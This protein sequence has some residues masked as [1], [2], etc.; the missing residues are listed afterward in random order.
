ME[1]RERLKKLRKDQEKTQYELAKEVGTSQAA[2][3]RLE[4]GDQ[5]PSYEVIRKL[6]KA[7][8]VSP[9]YLMGG[10]VRGEDIEELKPE[11]EAHF[12][13]YRGLNEEQQ[14][15]LRRFAQY[16]QMRDKMAKE[17]QGEDK[18]GTSS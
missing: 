6:S 1:F 4:A 16:V 15:E 8:N 17:E 5:N 13:Q 14:Q 11:E 7:L 12:R 3:S 18:G 10:K 2:I 9:S